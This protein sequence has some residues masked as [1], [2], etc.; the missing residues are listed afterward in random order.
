M[1]ARLLCAV[2]SLCRLIC[3][4]VPDH[5]GVRQ[6]RTAVVA[7]VSVDGASVDHVVGEF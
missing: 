4:L 3:N 6:I 1:R 7:R 5:S 2:A